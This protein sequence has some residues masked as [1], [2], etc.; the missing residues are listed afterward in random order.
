M[1]TQ[2]RF[3]AALYGVPERLRRT[4]EFLPEDIKSSVEEIRIRAGL[5][6][7]LTVK[8][9]TLFV[10]RGGNVADYITGDILKSTKEEAQ[11]SFL[12]LCKNSVYAHTTELKGGYI[13]M[14]GGN[15]AGVCGTFSKDGR[16]TQVTSVNIRIAREVY[17]SADIPAQNF[18]GGMLIAG[19]PCSGKTTV[20]R[21]LIRQL[22]SGARGIYYRIAVIDS[23]G[24]LS[25]GGGANNMGE[26][27]DVL[28][29]DNKA[30]GTEIA[31]RTLSPDI[32]AFDEIGTA[33][34]LKSISDCF[35][36]GVDIITTAHSSSIE[37]LKRRSVTGQLLSSG[38]ISTVVLLSKNIG[39]APQII[40]VEEMLGDFSS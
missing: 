25:G 30:L 38:M 23:R 6:I 3:D 1:L 11:E 17:G 31:L 34:E 15:R 22:S 12:L 40:D 24:E 16:L 18:C 13:M 4:L 9:Q 14:P 32:I 2:Q 19:P 10:C 33:A 20:L 26:N 29:I 37:D 27:T 8:G 5:P 7:S 39:A 28:M 36:A 35:N 21:D